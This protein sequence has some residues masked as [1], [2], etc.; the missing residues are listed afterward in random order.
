MLKERTG[1]SGPVGAAGLC[2]WQLGRPRGALVARCAR[3]GGVRP[4]CRGVRLA[5]SPWAYGYRI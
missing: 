5:A 4:S 2:N 1:A 3:P